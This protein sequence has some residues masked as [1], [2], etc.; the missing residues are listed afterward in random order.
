MKPWKS[1]SSASR[2]I[3]TLGL[4]T[5]LLLELGDEGGGVAAADRRTQLEHVAA[6]LGAALDEVR[7]VAHGAERARGRHA[8][9]AAADRR[10]RRG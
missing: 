8:G 5:S 9:D 4:S 1:A 10:P 3:L 6:E 7:L 2:W